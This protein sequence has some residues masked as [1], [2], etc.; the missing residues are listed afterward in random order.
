[1]KECRKIFKLFIVILLIIP[2]ST[3]QTFAAGNNST[4][5]QEGQNTEVFINDPYLEWIIRVQLDK[6]TEPLTTA[7]LE[8]ITGISAE[9]AQITSLEGLEYAKN[10]EVLHI[11]NNKI[12]DLSPLQNLT[13]LKTISLKGN[14]ISNIDDLSNLNALERVELSKNE[15]TNIQALANKPKLTELDLN[16]NNVSD[17]TP[18]QSSTHLENLELDDNEISKLG[19]LHTLGSLKKLSLFNNPINLFT[20]AASKQ[21]VDSFITKGTIVQGNDSKLVTIQD[22]NLEKAIREELDKQSGELT[23]GD[24]S[25]LTTLVLVDKG[26]KSLNGL[27]NAINLRMLNFDQNG[28]QDL[29]PIKSLVHLQQLELLN[30]KVAN[31]TPLSNMKDLQKIDLGSNAISDLTPLSNLSNITELT[32]SHNNI[33]SLTGISNLTNLEWLDLESN[34]ISDV[35][36][37]NKLANL[38]ML[39]LSGNQ[40]SSMDQIQG[41]PIP[42]NG[43]K[44]ENNPVSQAQPFDN[45]VQEV[46]K[47]KDWTIKFNIAADKSS[48]NADTVY[49]TSEDIK[50]PTDL[51]PTE[52][53]KSVQI[54]HPTGGYLPN[55]SYTIHV[56]KSVKTLNGTPLK[57][58]IVKQFKV[59]DD[60]R[61]SQN[62]VI[63]PSLSER[64]LLKFA[65]LSYLDF[66]KV[67]QG[68][69][70][71][72]AMKDSY[73]LFN[74]KTLY[75]K[76]KSKYFDAAFDQL[77]FYDIKNL[78]NPEK[79][80][81]Y[82]ETIQTLSLDEI[83]NWKVLDT[84]HRF[85]GF[86]AVAFGSPDLS[87]VVIAYRGSDQI[88]DWAGQDLD[89]LVKSTAGDQVDPA[90]DLKER[91]KN[92]YPN[93]QLFFTGHSLGGWLAQRIAADE[94]EISDDSSFTKAV[95][96]NAPGFSEPWKWGL[97]FDYL[98]LDEW[99]N[100]NT[101]KY[102]NH[103]DNVYITEDTVGSLYRH[104]GNDITFPYE[105]VNAIGIMPYHGIINFYSPRAFLTDDEA[106]NAGYGDTTIIR[107][108]WKSDYHTWY[109]QRQG[110][111]SESAIDFMDLPVKYNQS[112]DLIMAGKKGENYVEKAYKFT[113]PEDFK[114]TDKLMISPLKMS[115]YLNVRITKVGTGVDPRSIEPLVTERFTK[116]NDDFSMNLQNKLTPGSSYYL[117]LN[118]NANDMY[119]IKFGSESEGIVSGT[120]TNAF[121]GV[122]EGN[123]DLSFRKGTIDRP[124]EIV[125]KAKTDDNGNY[126]VSLPGGTYLLEITG[127]KIYKKQIYVTSLGNELEKDNQNTSVSPMLGEGE[128]RIVLEWGESPYDL[129]SHLTGP[130]LG[131]DERFH[132][133]FYDMEADDEEGNVDVAL[134]V[135]DTD[136]YGPETITIYKQH[137]GIYRYSVHDYSNRDN[138]RDSTELSNSGARVKVLFSD[139]S[140]KTFDVPKNRPGTLW[141][142]FEYDGTT[143]RPI[144]SL[145]FQEEPANIQSVDGIH[146]DQTND[147]DLIFDNAEKHHKG[148]KKSEN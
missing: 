135:D 46:D 34:Q 77:D 23:K 14:E 49:V 16:E 19:D 32:V 61:N 24:L 88:R 117:F 99:N 110:P 109:D 69:T 136:Q 39:D 25:R 10:L 11:S 120:I 81:T 137:S 129:D 139:G 133:N 21:M 89:L 67:K 98:T 101:E 17:I 20:D 65:N 108:L 126:S 12:S 143:I 145:G 7:D 43:V 33:E 115:E 79:Q 47:N 36:S 93:A 91:I 148:T 85:N 2:F 92:K 114:P 97:S 113:L 127:E 123:L 124:G 78:N 50:V 51:K 87:K 105:H 72:E 26:I 86:Y 146:S 38:D 15:I 1:M 57:R 138:L 64:K 56:T 9:N 122:G 131:S 62:L 134:D 6:K 42:A 18:I 141:T 35:G 70:V 130:I 144:N 111:G 121:S 53:G 8:K 80:F 3:I 55:A 31:L 40:I 54:I 44:L 118:G 48:I 63:E 30:N 13:K 58:A 45:D 116:T 140:V 76:W 75:K 107:D 29:T 96:F 100:R 90:L 73:G 95:T 103:I 102:K 28:V 5:D 68:V 106:S 66:H 37:L 22:Q 125:K 74:T 71:E 112:I 27:E 84:D 104:L 59:K 147:A 94:L 83:K 41:L 119:R 132:I 52:D 60:A 142:V 4:T 82:R 128:I